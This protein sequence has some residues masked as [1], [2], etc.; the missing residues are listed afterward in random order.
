MQ[1]RPRRVSLAQRDPFAFAKTGTRYNSER[2]DL[3]YII[4]V[5][6]TIYYNVQ[7]VPEDEGLISYAD[8]YLVH[9]TV[10]LF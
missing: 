9:Y 4:Y 6:Y 5:H 2:R 3:L 10:L 8:F 1:K 7:D